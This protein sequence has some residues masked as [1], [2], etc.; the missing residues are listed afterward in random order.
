MKMTLL[1]IKVGDLA[2]SEVDAYLKKQFRGVVV[3]L[4]LLVLL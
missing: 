2:R 3:F 4:T 1:R